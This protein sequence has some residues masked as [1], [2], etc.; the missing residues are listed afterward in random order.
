VNL[1]PGEDEVFEVRA[2]DDVLFSR[3]LEDRLPTID[4]IRQAVGQRIRT[5]RS[6]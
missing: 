5:A 1:V 4:E 6:G 2:G 3:E